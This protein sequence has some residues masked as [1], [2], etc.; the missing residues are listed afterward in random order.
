MSNDNTI[1]PV[2][3]IS[4]ERGEEL[5]KLSIGIV[6]E[7]TNEKGID[8][9]GMMKYVVGITPSLSDRELLFLSYTIGRMVQAI[10][11]NTTMPSWIQNLGRT[12]NDC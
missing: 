11:E 1:L 5:H 6:V 3:E 9:G 8:M 2:L 7:Y 10:I 4:K 12:W